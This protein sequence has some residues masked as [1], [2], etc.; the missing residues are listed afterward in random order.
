[1][2]CPRCAARDSELAVSDHAPPRK[3]ADPAAGEPQDAADAPELSRRVDAAASGEGGVR[4]PTGRVDRLRERWRRTMSVLRAPRIRIEMYGGDEGLDVYRA[5]T[6][7]HHR[8]K[9]TS[10]KRWGVALLRLPAS[11]DQYLASASRLARRRC[12][13]ALSLGYRY[14]TTAPTAHL[15]E[16]LEINRSA[17]S[18]QGRPMAANYVDRELVERTIGA[19]TKIHAIID[20]RGRLR[21]YADVVDIGDA[22][23]FSYLI[24]HADDLDDGIMYLLTSEVVRYCIEA[25]RSD[26]SPTWLM[27]DTFWGAS[28]GLAFFKERA[29]FRPFTVDWVWVDRWS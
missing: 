21:A 29:G 1:M 9:V 24:G 13:R 19:R 6:A 4:S 5:F 3:S 8:F 11:R 16:I 25:R 15:E 20:S 26:G 10:A 17:G 12:A 2:P 14:I 23:T 28:A 27:V 7:R 18:R 22:F